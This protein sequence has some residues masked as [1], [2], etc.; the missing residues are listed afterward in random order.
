MHARP[1][2]GPPMRATSRVGTAR[3]HALV[4][5]QREDSGR[6]QFWDYNC[7]ECGHLLHFISLLGSAAAGAGGRIDVRLG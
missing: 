2:R 6:V 4:D 3:V 5:G 7:C 1:A